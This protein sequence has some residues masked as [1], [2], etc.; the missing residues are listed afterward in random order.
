MAPTHIFLSACL[1]AIIAGIATAL[2]GMRVAD[3]TAPSPTGA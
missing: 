2:R 1:F 3:R